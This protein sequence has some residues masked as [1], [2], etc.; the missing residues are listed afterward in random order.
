MGSI[1]FYRPPQDGTL[2]N[3]P[4]WYPD[5][6]GIK[7][8][9]EDRFDKAI[10]YRDVVL[11]NLYAKLADLN[12]DLLSL[13][14][15]PNA[16][17]SV[18][19]SVLDTLNATFEKQVAP[20]KPNITVAFP[21]APADAVL[22][23]VSPFV[24]EPVPV[25]TRAEPIAKEIAPPSKF[26]KVAPT[27]EDLPVRG[28]PATPTYTLP[29]VP[30]ARALVL[31]SDPVID[32][33]Q[34]LGVTPDRLGTPTPYTFTFTDQD[35]ESALST[36]LKSTL[37]DLVLNF[38]QTG[39][40][41]TILNQ[42]W[43]QGRER[44]SAVM[45]GAVYN[46]SRLFAS[47]GWDLDTGSEAELIMQAMGAKEEQDILESRNIQVSEATLIQNNFQFSFTQALALEEQW[48]SHHDTQQ[49]RAL[50]SAKA[51][52]DAS[53]QYGNLLVAYLQAD[54]ALYTANATV[55]AERIK[56]SLN[57]LEIYRSK[58]EGL[59]LISELNQQDID[60]YKSQIEAIVAVFGLYKDQLEG[61]KIKIEADGLKVQQ[62]QGR[63]SAFAEERQAKAL[64]Y[65]GFKSEWGA[66]ETKARVF[67][68]IVDSF[69]AKADVMKTV[70]ESKL[71][72]MNADIKLNFDVPLDVLD[73]KTNIYKAKTDAKRAEIGAITD[74]YKTDAEVFGTL[75]SA[76]GTRVTSELKAVELKLDGQVKK[77]TTELEAFKINLGNILSQKELLISGE[78]KEAALLAQVA[79]SITGSVSH[80]C[81]ISGSSSYPN[82]E[83]LLVT[84]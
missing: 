50:D 15:N 9:T 22:G 69:K 8:Y 24:L 18:D 5:S 44:T 27:M 81:G 36:Q 73:K 11:S 38:R 76:E 13:Q 29:T 72:K 61:E 80:S 31:P 42:K 21:D 53:V 59:K 56:A 49:Q 47:A 2:G 10:A 58:L 37:L 1:T 32:D 68:S 25:L 64:E 14:Q 33:V 7:T 46:I 34:F 35:Y 45:Q 30:L 57:K 79:S 20:I 63:I 65:E 40:G 70:N 60:R 74:L 52:L 4:D 12:D 77:V 67:Q 48:M 84:T 28:F 54:V 75:T 71:Q 83:P 41:D 66:E 19:L 62:F 23:T 51:V 6:S 16:I 55:F 26:T 43:D 17:G 39:L 3:W 78:E 82:A